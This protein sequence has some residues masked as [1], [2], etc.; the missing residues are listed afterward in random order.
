M[1]KRTHTCTYLDTMG[2]MVQCRS[3][4]CVGN[5]LKVKAKVKVKVKMK[6]KKMKSNENENKDRRELM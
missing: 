1:Y 5:K 4:C 3:N 6:M 2:I